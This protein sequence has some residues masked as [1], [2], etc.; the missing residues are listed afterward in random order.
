MVM[1]L[2]RKWKNCWNPTM[3]GLIESGKIGITT[4]ALADDVPIHTLSS[5]ELQ[6]KTPAEKLDKKMARPRSWEKTGTS[7]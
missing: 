7:Q 5:L 4:R 6:C 3:D 1:G 2:G